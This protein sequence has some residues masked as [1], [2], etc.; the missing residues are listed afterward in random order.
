M[1]DPFNCKFQIL[2]ITLSK[3]LLQVLAMPTAS[4]PPPPPHQQTTNKQAVILYWV[5]LDAA[6]ENAHT[7]LGVQEG[8]K[9]Q[10]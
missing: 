10:M 6:E 3:S 1:E 8:K 9:N 4:V 5:L 2:A 7:F